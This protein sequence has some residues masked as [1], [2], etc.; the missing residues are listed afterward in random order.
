MARPRIFV[1]STYY[2][3]KYIRN[4][5]EIFIDGFGYESVLYEQGDIP[6]HHNNPLDVSCYDEIKRCHIL[7]LIVGGRYGSPAS[8]PDTDM[9][10][11][12]DFYNS[13]TKREYETARNN[14][15]PIY[16][17]V[18]KNVLSEYRTYKNNRD[19]D[20][21]KYAHVDNV[22]IFKLIDEIY[23]QGRNNLVKEFENFDDISSWLRDQWA[24]LFADYLSDRSRDKELEELSVQ[25]AGLKDI[26]SV[27][28]GYTESILEKIQP[29]NFRTMIDQSNKH[30]KDRSMSVFSENRLIEYIRS[31][32]RKRISLSKLFDVFTRS[33][34]LEDFL[35]RLG[36]EVELPI[37][38]DN[39]DAS[40]D[41]ESL[42][43]ELQ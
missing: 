8:E 23:A 24:G 34:S 28:K 16:I 4:S 22:Q 11:G 20:S 27:L 36:L 31:S 43:R 26:N 38:K 29:E 12:L 15:I 21:V 7:V 18:E 9:S 32:S 37:L 39:K 33:D 42:K 2:D 6:F 13:V 1:S 41:F 3:L 14:D 19:N 25:I 35:E 30:L 5:L 10:K 40:D 17:F